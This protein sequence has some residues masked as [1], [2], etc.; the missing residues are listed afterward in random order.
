VRHKTILCKKIHLQFVKV[1]NKKL[2]IIGGFTVEHQPL[3]DLFDKK[4]KM[5]TN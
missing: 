3:G 2:V 4:T 1:I 5:P